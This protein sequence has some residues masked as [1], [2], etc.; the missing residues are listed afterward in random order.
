M[1]LWPE[2]VY[3]APILLPGELVASLSEEVGVSE[4]LQQLRERVGVLRPVLTIGPLA[5]SL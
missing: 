5:E 3:G 4:C 1:H 2:L